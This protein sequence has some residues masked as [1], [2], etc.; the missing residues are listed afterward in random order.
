MA[1][2]AE[3]ALTATKLGKHIGARI[4]GVLLGGGLDAGVVDQI[5]EALLRH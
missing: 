2:P 5:H 3:I 4:D 1:R